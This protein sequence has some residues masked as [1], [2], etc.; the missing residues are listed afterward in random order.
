M[1]P[2]TSARE[3][4]AA[5]VS[6]S[7]SRPTSL[8]GLRLPESRLLRIGDVRWDPG[9]FGK[10]L[11]KGRGSQGR[12]KKERLVP[13]ANGSRDLLEWWGTG[14]RREF[15]DKIDD[16]RVPPFPSE[17]RYG[18][19]SSRPVDRRRLADRAGRGG[20]TARVPGPAH[21]T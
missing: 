11:L 16:P 17:R 14:P 6:S 21:S 1:K 13:P 4:I 18:D 8:I 2:G 3:R 7:S 20:R 9:R 10:V 5:L 12:G 19:G 15:D